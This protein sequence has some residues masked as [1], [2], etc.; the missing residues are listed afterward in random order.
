LLSKE[1]SDWYGGVALSW[2]GN[3][4]AVLIALIGCAE[5]EFS[6]S[7]AVVRSFVF[8]LEA[9]D[10]RRPWSKVAEG[11]AMSSSLAPRRL[12][13]RAANHGERYRRSKRIFS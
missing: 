6:L 10:L 7:F 3:L 9:L 4:I 8:V 1:E 11:V 2:Q 12:R 13:M 5:F